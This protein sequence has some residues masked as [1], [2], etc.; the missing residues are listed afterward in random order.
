MK[1]SFRASFPAQKYV[2]SFESKSSPV[3]AIF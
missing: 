3:L 1:R 2:L